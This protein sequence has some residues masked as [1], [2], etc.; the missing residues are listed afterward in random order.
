MSRNA[1]E[2]NRTSSGSDTI[3]QKNCHKQGEYQ[4]LF[5]ILFLA[6]VVRFIYIFAY[7]FDIPYALIPINDAET[8]WSQANTILRQG[9]LLPNAGVF[10]QPPLY[11][12]LLTPFCA[13]AE[14]NILPAIIF[15]QLLGLVNVFLTWNLARKVIAPSRAWIP[16]LL[17]GLAWPSIAYETKL[18]GATF[19]AFSILLLL[20][21]LVIIA[22]Q[23]TE[24]E[25]APSR[26]VIP[27]AIACGIIA[28]L[29][30]LLRPNM[31][32]LLP[33]LFIWLIRYGAK[34]TRYR[35][36]L[37]AFAMAF[38][39]TILPAGIRNAAIGGDFVPI[40]ANGGMAFYMGNNSHAAGGLGQAPD[41]PT[42]IR[43][44]IQ[45][46][47]QRASE[48]AG[49][50]LKPSEASRFWLHRG[51][52]WMIHNPSPCA[53]LLIK[54]AVLTFS[55]LAGG[56]SYDVFNERALFNTQRGFQNLANL[57]ILPF[58]FILALGWGTLFL[59]R[60]W[61]EPFILLL[62]LPTAAGVGTS[63]LFYASIRFL[64]PVLPCL[65]IIGVWG[66]LQIWDSI[67]SQTTKRFVW[68]T[69]VLLFVL[70]FFIFSGTRME[71]F[72]AWKQPHYRPEI[73]KAVTQYNLGVCYERLH[74]WDL[75]EQ[76]YRE[77]LRLNPDNAGTAKNLS[78]LY[79]NAGRYGEAAEV[80][81]EYLERFPLNAN[82]NY[83][84]ALTHYYSGRK[85][86]ALPYLERALSVN[87]NYENALR[88]KAEI[89]RTTNPDNQ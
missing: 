72:L 28:G 7:I 88:L 47:V 30:I 44:Q 36:D 39:L 67:H 81:Q 53:V 25:T 66:S 75:A 59:S 19:S 2:T 48:L 65:A 1:L 14:R 3:P 42:N 55:G 49:Q 46:D 34:T 6:L 31:L 54:K 78:S 40:C 29:A 60:F 17:Y 16:A 85:K 22:P 38:I 64:V 87:P 80:L 33:L 73:L 63:L 70:F 74:S 57:L 43:Q 10:Y 51:L 45:A 82:L 27:I 13:F 69:F 71:R 8:A 62:L 12:Y 79:G 58:V 50:N 24:K 68:P 32:L 4:S 89:L 18:V 61:R 15:Q 86:E 83:N 37:A 11:P 23:H 21:L 20:N 26:K 52:S 41:I 35:L 56:V 84:M 9:L 77:S 76:A 5:F